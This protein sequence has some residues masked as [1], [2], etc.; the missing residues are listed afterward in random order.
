[1]CPVVRVRQR[2]VEINRPCAKDGNDQPPII[3]L[4]RSD[5]TVAFPLRFHL[6][7][8]YAPAIRPPNAGNGKAP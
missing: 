4:L 7:L 1:M 6:N 2:R 8:Q 5:N 3:G